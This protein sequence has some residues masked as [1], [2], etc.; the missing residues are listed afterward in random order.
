MCP[1]MVGF[2]SQKMGYV[3]LRLV[4]QFWDDYK[5]SPM[6][7]L[8]TARTRNGEQPQMQH[9]DHMKALIFLHFLGTKSPQT[10]PI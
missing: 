7:E 3:G 2:T 1:K 5:G 6:L 8:W 10:K 9:Y 4:P